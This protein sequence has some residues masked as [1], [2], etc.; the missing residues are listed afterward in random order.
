M[1]DNIN[2]NDDDGLAS[3][4]SNAEVSLARIA[5]DGGVE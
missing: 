2:V 1:I 3:N 4:V 5:R